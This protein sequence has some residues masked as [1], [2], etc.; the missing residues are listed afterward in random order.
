MQKVGKI[1]GFWGNTSRFFEAIW[2]FWKWIPV[3]DT[4][5]RVVSCI[6]PAKFQSALL[7][8][9]VTA[10]LQMIKTSLHWWKNAPTLL[11][12]E[13]PQGSDSVISAFSTM[14]SLVIGQIRTDEN[15]M[16]LQLSLNLLTCWILKENHHNWCDGLPERYCREDTKTG[17]DYLFAVKGNQGRLNKAFEKN[18]CW[19]N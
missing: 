8:G 18:F 3:H 10:I 11:W 16:R 7:T 17:G 6:S 15:L 4:I 13:S 2:W 14:H 1:W 19:K 5:A 12:Q 9:C